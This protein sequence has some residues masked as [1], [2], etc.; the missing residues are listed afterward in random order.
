MRSLVKLKNV[1]RVET[2][3]LVLSFIVFGLVFYITG[4]SDVNFSGINSFNCVDESGVEGVSCLD[5]ASPDVADLENKRSGGPLGNYT[6]ST[7]I[8]TR[9]GRINVLF[10]IDY[11]RSMREELKSIAEQFEPFLS[12]IKR[13]DY[14]IAIITTNWLTDR[15]QFVEFSNGENFLSNPEKSNRVHKTNIRLFTEAIERGVSADTSDERGIYALNMALDNSAHTQFFRSHSL[16]L[17]VIV[18]DEDERSYGG[19]LPKGY[20]DINNRL[21]PLEDYDYPETFFRKVSQQQ[22]FS[23]VAVHSIIVKPNDQSCAQQSGGVPGRIYAKASNPSRSVLSQYGNISKGHIG[24]IC[25]R[26]Y[27]NQLGPIAHKLE[28]VP[29]IPLPCFP[30]PQSVRVK[31]DDERVRFN[32]EGR[33]V[34]IKEE[35]SFGDRAKIFFR[36][37]QAPASQI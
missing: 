32:L 11:S 25:S 7:V 27:S 24:S 9:I 20:H 34:S 28:V 2:I 18:S 10:V 3:V 5:P 17:V 29:A 21:L 14:Q 35:V 6:P 26:D 36:C 1:W 31:I 4:C 12:D 15:G 8:N 33:T 37:Q 30:F 19:H 23:T 16:L 13:A 22:K